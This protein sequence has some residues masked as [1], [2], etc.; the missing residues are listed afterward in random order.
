MLL[1]ILIVLPACGAPLLMCVT[2][3][4]YPSMVELLSGEAL[5]KSSL[6]KSEFIS[7]LLLDMIFTLLI[8]FSI[9]SFELGKL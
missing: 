8:T 9:F 3:L 7:A 4:T 5:W 1:V 2:P 6:R